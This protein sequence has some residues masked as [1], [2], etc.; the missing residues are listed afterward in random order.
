MAENTASV[1][2]TG[3]KIFTEAERKS[4]M[5]AESA[6]EEEEGSLVADVEMTDAQ[7][8]T[9]EL[10]MMAAARE[11]EARVAEEKE[12]MAR[13]DKHNSTTTPPPKKSATAK[14]PPP[15]P[16]K[17]SKEKV[18]LIQSSMYCECCHLGLKH[19]ACPK[20][21]KSKNYGL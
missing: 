11:T 18:R 6:M 14:A 2:P 10:E 21:W 4:M 9:L 8:S 15:T 1:P 17:P 19:N 3:G 5:A 7:P 20:I 12:R 16:K 13:E